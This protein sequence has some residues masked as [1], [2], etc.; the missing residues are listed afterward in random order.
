MH[1][2]VD[3][4][5]PFREWGGSVAS[6]GPEGTAGGD[7]AAAASDEGGQESDDQQTESSASGSGGLVV[8]LGKGETVNAGDDL[9]EVVDRVEDG[10]HVNNT[11]D[12][13][14]AHLGQDSLRDVTAGLGDFFRQMRGAVRSSHTVSTVKHSCNKNESLTLVA[15]SILPFVP[16]KVIGRIRLAVDMGHDCADNDRNENT[17]ENKEHA[18]V[19]DIWKNAVQEQDDAATDP[20]A[21][22]ET[23]EDMPG[24]W[25]EAGIH[26]GVHRN[27]LLAEDR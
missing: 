2:A 26:E 9:W 15:G 13:P 22:D 4:A 27:G 3:P 19:A 16:D 10:N 6:K 24:F 18:Q 12:E 25:D 7:V 14:N 8:N 1:L 11:G 20:C 23:D 21:D 17:S 5:K